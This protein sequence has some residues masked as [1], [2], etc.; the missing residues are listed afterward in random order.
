MSEMLYDDRVVMD[1][2]SYVG[3]YWWNRTRQGDMII[4][5]EYYCKNNVILMKSYKARWCDYIKR[6]ISVFLISVFCFLDWLIWRKYMWIKTQNKNTY[7][8]HITIVRRKYETN[9]WTKSSSTSPQ[10]FLLHLSSNK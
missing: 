4:L 1:I 2:K 5:W 7:E 9:K 3:E 8:K 6:I 10:V